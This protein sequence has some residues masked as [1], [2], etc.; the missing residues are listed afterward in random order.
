M[1]NLPDL[2]LRA[3]G[4]AM[5]AI[6][7]RET[8]LVHRTEACALI[9]QA[10]AAFEEC[11][12]LGEAWSAEL[13]LTELKRYS[14]P[15]DE[16]LIRYQA[17]VDWVQANEPEMVLTVLSWRG[18][19]HLDNYRWAEAAED[20]AYVFGEA[21]NRGFAGTTVL[22]GLSLMLVY[23]ALGRTAERDQCVND[24]GAAFSSLQVPQHRAVY[25]QNLSVFALQDGKLEEAEKL[26]RLALEAAAY[27]DNVHY[28]GPIRS[29]LAR[30]LV[31]RARYDDARSLLMANE[32]AIDSHYWRVVVGTMATLSELDLMAGNRDRANETFCCV[33]WL[34]SHWQPILAKYELDLIDMLA[35]NLEPPVEKGYSDEEI[36]NI[37]T[38]QNR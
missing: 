2:S 34:V 13:L 36:R 31:H 17:I 11:G 32:S 15:A 16:V 7:W 3:R 30:V 24:V 27:T 37:L 6:A 29:T 33:Q 18:R 20:L 10:K 5:M 21:K 38:W 14:M 22:S 35:S 25:C 4:T 23:D 19:V 1:L 9:E 28:V 12:D 26:A 8:G